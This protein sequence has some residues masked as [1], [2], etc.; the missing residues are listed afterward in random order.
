MGGPGA[1]MTA[2]KG[3]GI[4]DSGFAFALVCVCAVLATAAA[5][6]STVR[7]KVYSQDQAKGGKTTYDN[8]CASCHDGGTMGPEL[9]GTSFLE[10]WDGKTVG[11]FFERIKSTMPE[12]SPGTL[13]EAELLNVIA[14]VIQ[15]NGFPAGDAAMRNESALATMTFVRNK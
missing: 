9:W 2:H 12:D 5:A 4:W 13:T 7:D 3:L 1:A 15:T 10:S 11:T 14:Y 6:D 8:K